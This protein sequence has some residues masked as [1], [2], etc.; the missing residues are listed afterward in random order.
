MFSKMLQV[1]GLCGQRYQRVISGAGVSVKLG[2]LLSIFL[3]TTVSTL[4]AADFEPVDATTLAAWLTAGVSSARLT[5]LVQ[6]RGIA[7]VFTK[8]ECL[9][10]Q[11]SGAD[12]TFLRALRTAKPARAINPSKPI[13][14]ILLKAASAAHS[15]RYHEAEL[16]LRDLLRNDRQNAALH[17]AL[18]AMLRQQE[19][20]DDAFAE[21]TESA[22]LMP[23]F[24]ENH[25]S[26]AYIFF[27]MDDGPNAI[28]EA[29][30][31][32]SMDPKNPEAYQILG[33][34]LYSNGQYAAAVHAFNDSLALDPDNAD[35]YYDI[36]IA[37]H[38][39]GDKP[40]ALAAYHK[41]IVLR[42]AFW[43]AHSNLGLTL[44]EQ[45]KL[46]EALA[47]YLEAKRL[48]PEEPSVRNNLGNTYCDLGDFDAAITEMKELYRRHPEWQQG[49]GCLASAYMAK[50]NYDAAVAELQL[51]LQQN[52]T[53]P[54]EHRV[55]GQALLLDDQ[56]EAA[57]RELRLAVSLNPDSDA[58]HHFLGTALIEQQQLQAA[59]KEFREA[60]R[61][62]PSAD[63]HY[64]LAACLMSMNRYEEASAELELASQLDPY[65]TVY[66]AHR[67]ELMK[68]MKSPK[69]R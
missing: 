36:G 6:E 18:G 63:N 54:L 50:R 14:S 9:Q 16:L 13:P 60:L 21:I 46:R 69:A 48:A 62:N 7:H 40:G 34:A 32:L 33:L 35:T 45:G 39:D 15:R 27:R 44:H 31:A 47:E 3:L 57:I 52:P 56:P 53:G 25:I 20:W 41:A 17:F 43:E 19:Q 61:L 29:R 5:R 28:A 64:S 23:D 24:A 55:L 11:S 37:L 4:Y 22:R 2:L 65:R 38:A 12:N 51:G 66:R 58:S 30:T 8:E 49:H 10:L 26:F 42:P 1:S 59:E 67:D 68:L